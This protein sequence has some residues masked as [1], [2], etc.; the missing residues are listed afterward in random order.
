MANTIRRPV[1]T[2]TP[3]ALKVRDSRFYALMSRARQA[4]R[5]TQSLLDE[6]VDKALG[7][8]GMLLAP[9]A[10]L[11]ADC[12]RCHT[13]LNRNTVSP[14][15]L[16]EGIWAC[17]FCFTEDVQWREAKIAERARG[18]TPIN[19]AVTRAAGER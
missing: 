8:A 18:V 1:R 10:T 5:S 2:W 6:L 16:G 12:D 19:R 17:R 14:W 11:A 9:G 15:L 7:D 4:K 3:N 13:K